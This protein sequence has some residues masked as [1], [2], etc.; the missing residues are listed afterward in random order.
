MTWVAWRVQRAQLLAGVLACA[1]L[2]AF[3]FATGLSMGHDPTWKYWTDGVT[4]LLELLPGLLGLGVGAPLVAAELHQ[5]TERLAF[6][7]S[8]SRRHWLSAK[9]LL[10]TGLT[11]LATALL[12]LLLWW[13]T[14]AVS[15]PF[16]LGS[17]G[18]D[19]VR[20][21]P[22]GFDVTGLVV[23]Y[24]LFA[25][26]LGTALGAFLRRPGWAFAA[27]LPL[28][29]AV[30]LTIERWVR[31]GL[32]AP[33]AVVRLGGFARFPQTRGWVLHQGVLPAGRLAPAPGHSWTAFPSTLASCLRSVKVS[34]A[35]RFEDAQRHCA[36][37]THLR[38]VT[39]YQPEGHYWPLQGGEAGIFLVT[40]AVLAGLTF[41]ALGWSID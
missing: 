3:L 35:S 24:T 21:Q 22:V 32:V 8:V 7:Q 30:R 28:F 34:S 10:A 37:V 41:L 17:G 33:A 18:F 23:A 25:F 31:P 15:L 20:V 38:F 16:S 12:S 26:F 2:A 29:A 6:S 19:G 36:L 11:A 9:L 1:A 13:W 5:G 40:A 27:G 4:V 39:Q 14:G